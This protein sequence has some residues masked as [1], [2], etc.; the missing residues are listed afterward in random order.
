MNKT[1]RHRIEALERQREAAQQPELAVPAWLRPLW[2]EGD[3]PLAYWK[4]FDAL[5]EAIRRDFIYVIWPD[6]PR[7]RQL[8]FHHAELNREAST[9]FYMLYEW[10]E[11]INDMV[12][13]MPAQERPATIDDY[14]AFIR[15][16]RVLFS[17]MWA[18]SDEDRATLCNAPDDPLFW[19]EERQQLEARYEQWVETCE[20]LDGA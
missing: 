10:R 12:G 11:K 1:F 20:H 16:V 5:L 9:A 14:V 15:E 6:Q 7:F 18:L 2:P 13:H 17:F 8:A 3:S 4:G 19:S